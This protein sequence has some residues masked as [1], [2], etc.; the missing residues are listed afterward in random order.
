MLLLI[1]KECLEDF[2]DLS[3]DVSLEAADDFAFGFA[4]VE[5]AFDVVAGGFVPAHAHEGK[6]RREAEIH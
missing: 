4:F 2:V 3:G 6:G 5:A 1:V